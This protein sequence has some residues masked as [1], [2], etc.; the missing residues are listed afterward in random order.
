MIPTASS[1]SSLPRSQNQGRYTVA[2]ISTYDLNVYPSLYWVARAL[3]ARGCDCRMLSR[4]EPR[5]GGLKE[6]RGADPDWIPIQTASGP[7][8]RL[9]ILHGDYLGILRR[10]LH[11][12][13][14]AVIAQHGTAVSA[15]VYKFLCPSLGRREPLVTAYFADYIARSWWSP[16]LKRGAGSLDAY[17]DVCDLRLGW[18]SQDWPALPTSRF[19]IRN[20]PPRAAMEAIAAHA[21]PARIL[22]TGRDYGAA[23]RT[24]LL[25]RFVERLC[26][27]GHRVDWRMPGPEANRERLRRQVPVVGF[28][29][30]PALDKATLAAAM[31]AYDMG[32]LWTPTSAEENASSRSNYVSAAPNKLGEYLAAGLAVAHTGNPGLRFLPDAVGFAIDPFAPE[33]SADRLSELLQNRAALEHMRAAALSFHLENLNADAQITPFTDWLTFRLSPKGIPSNT[34]SATAK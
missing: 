9:P 17:V 25:L 24:D 14:D 28:Q 30:L 18:R 20:A 4:I 1:S 3:E 2:L 22:F 26:A 15:L 19:V 23:M 27:S 8:A 6:A 32:I 7:L 34:D 31:P 21:G 13:P 5:L 10:L 16:W 11:M 33:A 12:R 29:M